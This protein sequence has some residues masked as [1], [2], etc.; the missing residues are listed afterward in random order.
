MTPLFLDI[1]E[2]AEAEISG[3]I[4]YARSLG[5]DI[6]AELFAERVAQVFTKEVGRLT[7]EVA[8]NVTGK[9]FDQPD[10]A[11]S[12][13]W[14]QSVY[15]PKTATLG[16][17]PSCP[18]SPSALKGRPALCRKAWMYSVSGLSVADLARSA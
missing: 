2:P 16:Y 6:A 14:A 4:E 3:A 12:S 9:P 15:R 8:A 7:E 18:V 10:E 5:G 11:A 17:S 1:T 13:R